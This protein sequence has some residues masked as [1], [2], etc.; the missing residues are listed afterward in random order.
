[1]PYAPKWEQQEKE[2]EKF[3]RNVYKRFISGTSL[4]EADAIRAPVRNIRDFN[5]FILF[6]RVYISPLRPEGLSGPPNLLSN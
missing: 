3:I 4:L 5:I 1:M 2:R 6:F